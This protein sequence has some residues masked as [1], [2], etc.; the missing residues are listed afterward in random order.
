MDESTLRYC[1]GCLQ[2]FHR[3]SSK[4]M[5][6]VPKAFVMAATLMGKSTDCKADLCEV[7]KERLK[8]LLQRNADLFS[9]AFRRTGASTANIHFVNKKSSGSVVAQFYTIYSMRDIYPFHS[10]CFD[11]YPA[12]EDFRLEAFS[13]YKCSDDNSETPEHCRQ[14]LWVRSAQSGFRNCWEFYMVFARSF[15]TPNQRNYWITHLKTFSQS[16][17]KPGEQPAPV[18]HSGFSL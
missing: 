11:L 13:R 8:K 10:V 17:K 1:S 14:E 5:V 3:H 16:P 4:R 18:S 15:P 9:G 12:T 7:C 2:L 6:L